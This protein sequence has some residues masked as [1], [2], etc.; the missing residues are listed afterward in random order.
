MKKTELKNPSILEKA[1]SFDSKEQAER[2]YLLFLKNVKEKTYNKKVKLE[3]HHVSSKHEGGPNKQ[4]NLIL[5]SIDDL[6]TC[7]HLRCHVHSVRFLQN[8]VLLHYYRFLAY[9]KK[10][11]RLAYLFRISDTEE[12]SR[13]RLLW[14]IIEKQNVFFGIL[15]GKE[16]KV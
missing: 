5:V 13:S 3:K 8:H 7:T 12:S 15:N 1:L 2:F 10:G 14:K 9:G 6:D 11:D 4:E 16:S